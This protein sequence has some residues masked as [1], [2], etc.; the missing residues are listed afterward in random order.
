MIRKTEVIIT[1]NAG[2][3]LTVEWI[4]G[5]EPSL[6]AHQSG[7]RPSMINLD[8]AARRALIQALGGIVDY[9]SERV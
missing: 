9:G 1:D 4:E 2:D 8:P 5:M 7:R 6:T 3:T